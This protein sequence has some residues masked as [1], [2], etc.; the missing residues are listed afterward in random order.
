MRRKAILIGLIT[1]LVVSFNWNEYTFNSLQGESYSYQELTNNSPMVILFLWTTWC[2][3]CRSDLIK[4]NECLSKANDNLTIYYVNL[5]ESKKT[6]EKLVKRTRLEDCVKD[7]IILD[8]KG[9]LADKFNIMFVP[10]YIFLK[11][12]KFLYKSNYLNES[13]INKV[14]SDE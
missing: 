6:V 13:L 12:G 5:G 9:A 2:P 14:F 8:K 7:N 4:N 1:F 11:N 3:T 10:T